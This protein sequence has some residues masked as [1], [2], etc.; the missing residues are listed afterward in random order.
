ML[1]GA[2]AQGTLTADAGT[3]GALPR[4]AMQPQGAL[5]PEKAR[6]IRFMRAMERAVSGIQF[7]SGLWLAQFDASRGTRSRSGAASRL[8][9]ATAP[10]SVPEASSEPLALVRALVLDAA[11]QLK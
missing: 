7:E 4:H 3:M 6:Q 5:D 9:L 2:D 11:Y 10:Q 8:L 1:P